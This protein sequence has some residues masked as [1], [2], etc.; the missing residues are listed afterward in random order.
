MNILLDRAFKLLTDLALHLPDELPRDVRSKL[1]IKTSDSKHIGPDKKYTRWTRLYQ[2][3]CGTD[4]ERGHHASKR[5]HI[6]WENVK[7]SMYARV[8]STHDERDKKSN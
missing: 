7:C 6:P 3:L 8:I 2:C 5:R 1:A 4:N